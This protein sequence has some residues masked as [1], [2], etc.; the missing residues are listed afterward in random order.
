MEKEKLIEIIKTCLQTLRNIKNVDL[1]MGWG[2]KIKDSWEESALKVT[3]IYTKNKKRFYIT[4]H[5]MTDVEIED[6]LE[7]SKRVMQ[8]IWD[9]IREINN[10]V[11]P[12]RKSNK[13]II[14]N[15]L[16]DYPSIPLVLERG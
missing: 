15:G 8:T 9:E 6:E 12:K 4:L 1:T 2:T 14:I 3:F 7:Y 11:K 13:L 5:F 10:K 16:A